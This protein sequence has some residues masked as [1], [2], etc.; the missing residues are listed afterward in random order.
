[1]NPAAQNSSANGGWGMN[2]AAQK[3]PT[4][5]NTAL[6]E[7]IRAA[8]SQAE[9]MNRDTTSHTPTP[10]TTFN[11]NVARPAN[12]GTAINPISS[13]P[14]TVSSS[15]SNS[16]SSAPLSA[17]AIINA[18]YHSASELTS[19][20]NAA[21]D[22]NTPRA[23]LSAREAINSGSVAK[24]TDLDRAK[25]A[26]RLHRGFIQKSLESTRTSASALLK[27]S[28]GE[29]APV[30]KTSLKLGSEARPK[31]PVVTLP[32]NARM[33]RA[34]KSVDRAS[35]S[36]KILSKITKAKS[37]DRR[38]MD[39]QII[40]PDSGKQSIAP[41]VSSVKKLS[42][43]VS[44][45]PVA[46][47]KPGHKII[48]QSE[49]DD[50]DQPKLAKR[51]V[52]QSLGISRKIAIID[53]NEDNEDNRDKS[54]GK[55]SKSRQAS[56]SGSRGTRKIVDPQMVGAHTAAT[57]GKTISTS[58]RPPRSRQ[59]NSAASDLGVIEDYSDKSNASN[60]PKETDSSSSASGLNARNLKN[61]KAHKAEDSRRTL[62]KQSPFFLKSVTVEKRPLSHETAGTGHVPTMPRGVKSSKDQSKLS[63]LGTVRTVASKSVFGKSD[64]RSKRKAKDISPSVNIDQPTVIVPSSHRSSAPLAFLVVMTVLLGTAVGAAVYLCFFQ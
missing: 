53:G 9:A 55:T 35:S 20:A 15:S 43:K 46:T 59:H 49:D 32:P 18:R 29:E 27:T 6:D 58:S 28:E 33:A 54:S 44:Q 22:K 34:A 38:S 7:A 2:F 64:P 13:A 52:R 40:L 23:N 16:N 4:N 50:L 62:G 57:K 42:A 11:S 56:S 36:K 37:L 39:A 48:V 31:K 51:P 24:P 41:T 3:I 63:S 61:P 19:G 14:Q 21:S 10:P 47:K 8:K 25:S 30:V 60:R 26:S 45:I 12:P 5:Q 17:Q 1:M